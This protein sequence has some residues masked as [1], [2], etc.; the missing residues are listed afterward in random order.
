MHA[1]K[2]DIFE[3]R[4]GHRLGM[5]KTQLFFLLFAHVFEMREF[6]LHLRPVL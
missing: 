4:T 5:T 2:A 3:M 6:S 1:I